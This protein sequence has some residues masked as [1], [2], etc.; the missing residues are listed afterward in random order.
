[1]KKQLLIAALVA[2]I[3]MTSI[4]AVY[5][6]WGQNSRKIP[7]PQSQYTQL[8]PA[9]QAKL[10]A[11]FADTEGIRKEMAVK[12]GEKQA[13]IRSGSGDPAAISKVE[14]ELFELRTAIRQKAEEA[15]VTAYLGPNNSPGGQ[16]QFYGANNGRGR[17]GRSMNAMP[18]RPG[19]QPRPY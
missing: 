17:G 2:G 4:T 19:Y 1:M 14:G 15:G 5:G 16:R 3:G 7:G 13:L 12:R 10:D 8:D 9:V 11:F 18:N 6:G